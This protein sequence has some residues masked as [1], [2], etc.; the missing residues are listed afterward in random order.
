MKKCLD[1]LKKIYEGYSKTTMFIYL[2]IKILIILILSTLMFKKELSDIFLCIAVFFL[3]DLPFYLS[4]KL[5]I[6][7]PNCLIICSFVYL[8][9]TQILG[10]VC[11]FYQLVPHW[12]SLVHF[13][14]GFLSSSIGFSLIM[15]LNSR[16]MVFKLSIPFIIL[17]TICFASTVGLIW[18]I[19]EYGADN[20]LKL[21][22]QNDRYINEI[23]TITLD[24]KNEGDI[25][26][27]KNIGYTILY[28]K[29]NI[30]LIK[31]DGY[32]DIGIH[33]TMKDLIVNTLGTI[34]FVI[35]EYL[36]MVNNKKYYFMEN[37]I[38]KRKW[39]K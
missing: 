33:D 10:E 2:V 25:I 30:E 17:N 18:E 14:N 22:S 28:D 27:I 36:Y 35:F 19:L 13:L 15:L 24:P 31:L 38:I 5:K 8:F 6:K 39:E 3:L 37:F 1:K 32:L 4:K 34:T 7:I 21:D 23:N 11:H 12:D 9:F 16:K 26:S 20:I 29:D